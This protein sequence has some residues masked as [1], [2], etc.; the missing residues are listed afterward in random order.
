MIDTSIENNIRT[1]RPYLG[2]LLVGSMALGLGLMITNA[3]NQLTHAIE[4]SVS[5]SEGVLTLSS[6][7]AV[8]YGD[9]VS[10][11]VSKSAKGTLNVYI[12]TV[13][14]Q[15]ATMVFQKSTPQG[16][17]VRLSNQSDSEHDW[18]GKAA[19]CTALLMYRT[20][21]ADTFDTF[22]I[23]SESFDVQAR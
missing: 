23:D 3:A 1:I 9:T 6:S 8:N 18:N 20:E 10:Y 16:A 5:E 21:R 15:G 2:I 11:N 17:S 14:F 22:L 12:T 7:G 13:C 19:S 4:P